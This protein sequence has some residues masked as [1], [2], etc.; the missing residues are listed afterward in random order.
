VA[1]TF[2]ITFVLG[3]VDKA[4]A[5]FQKTANNAQGAAKKAGQIQAVGLA[6]TA[7]I[8]A[9]VLAA[10][11]ASF[12]ASVEF[13]KAMANISTV[14]DT[15][16]ENVGSMG[17]EVLEIS[18]R[19]PKSVGD[20][21]DALYDVRSAGIAASQQ[22]EVLEGSARLATV[23]LGSTK[24]ATD[25]VTSAIN[26]WGLSG[27]KA[28][29]VYDTVFATVNVGKT[30][31]SGL[32]QGFGGVAGTVAAAGVELDDYLASVAALTTT[33]LPASEAHTQLKAVI[34]GLTRETKE[35]KKVF[36]ALGATDLPELIRESGG[37]AAAL[38]RISGE[39]D[40]DAKK[41][42]KLFGSTEALNAALGLTGKQADAQ[43]SALELMRSGTELVTEA[44]EKQ[45]ATTASK[46]QMV[47]NRLEATA[48]TIGQR[49][50]P[51]FESLARTVEKTTAWFDGLSET[52]QSM[53]LWSAA[54]VAAL[55]PVVTTVGTATKVFYGLRAAALAATAATTAG[56]ASAAGAGAAGGAAAAGGSA[57]LVPA[58]A[59]GVLAAGD[60]AANAEDRRRRVEAGY[61]KSTDTSFWEKIKGA[62]G[63][64]SSV[65]MVGRGTQIGASE[66]GVR[67]MAELERLASAASGHDSSTAAAKPLPQEVTVKMDFR[68]MPDG[69]RVA[70]TSTGPKV[71]QKVGKVLTAE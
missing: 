21:A 24:E 8:T 68:N 12:N 28:K 71:E 19:T 15:T 50:L 69:V 31:I 30:T 47:K 23:G 29:R 45:A 56:A 42:L 67:R 1:K 35:G 38:Q 40:G 7:G 32:A 37:L 39:L 48:I 6:M 20:L 55:G 44:F 11:V 18:K 60:A 16:K 58:A 2:P 61:Q 49:L 34:S 14:V 17:R 43:R 53:V 70:T 3:A 52:E 26:A 57:L 13:E 46:Q 41:M 62:M 59:V 25:I 4:S 10:G 66:A 54:I 36:R 27:E 22:F 65:G 51:A 5:V 33:G 63:G 9:P 64:T